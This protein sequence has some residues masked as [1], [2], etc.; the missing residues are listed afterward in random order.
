MVEQALPTSGSQPDP[1]FDT[2]LTRAKAGDRT[3][4]DRLL[5][6]VERDMR[7]RIGARIQGRSDIDRDEVLLDAQVYLFEKIGVFDPAM[8]TFRAFALGLTNTII[9][10][11][12]DGKP[13]ESP[14]FRTKDGELDVLTEPD[15]GMLEGLD[16]RLRS[17]VGADHVV[18]AG[19][20]ATP[21]DVFLETLALFFSEGGYPHQQIAFAFSQLI[22]GQRKTELKGAKTSRTPLWGAADRVVK[23]VSDW[24]LENARGDF[25]DELEETLGLDHD[26]LDR[27]SEPM[28]RR[29]EL[30]GRVLFE[31]DATSRELF[32]TLLDRRIGETRLS[33]YYGD[34]PTKSVA[35]WTRLVK[36]KITKALE[37]QEIAS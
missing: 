11:L 26:F 2:L 15:P 4:C 7:A 30:L 36:N 19:A 3:A 28:R 20:R 34:E 1:D 23:E 9:R 5:R 25:I 14:V 13:I 33:D 12:W 10:R 22:W 21:G 17:V 18:H 32:R 24:A 6:S 8:G 35:N 31:K 27:M 29:L 16:E 37:R